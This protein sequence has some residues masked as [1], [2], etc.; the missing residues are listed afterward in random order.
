MLKKKKIEIDCAVPENIQ[1]H[2]PH[3]RDW[4][5]KLELILKYR[6]EQLDSELLNV[7]I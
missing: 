6:F 5:L 3:G 1:P 2:S 7:Y 4:N